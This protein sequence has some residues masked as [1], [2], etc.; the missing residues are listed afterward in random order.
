MSIGEFKH[1]ILFRS[2]NSVKEA[3]GGTVDTPADVLTTFAK[4][5]PVRG[6]RSLSFSQIG[7]YNVCDFTIRFR[8]DFFPNEKMKIVFRSDNYTIHEVIEV[9]AEQRFWLITAYVKQPVT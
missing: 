2:Y 9:K 6:S 7:L 5:A 8:E 1:K 4:V 3:F